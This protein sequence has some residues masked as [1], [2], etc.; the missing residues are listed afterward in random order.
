MT[1]RQAHVLPFD[2]RSIAAAPY[3]G[4]GR[5]AEYRIE[6][7]P[8]LILAVVRPNRKGEKDRANAPGACN[9]R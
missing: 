3:Y 1:D 6:G 9:I 5:E 7:N 4:S 8:G 2:D